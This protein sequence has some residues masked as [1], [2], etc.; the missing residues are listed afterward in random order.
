MEVVKGDLGRHYL[1]KCYPVLSF[2][3]LYSDHFSS[4]SIFLVHSKKISDWRTD[5]PNVQTTDPPNHQ[6]TYRLTH[7]PTDWLTD[8]PIDGQKDRPSYKVAMTQLKSQAWSLFQSFI[9][10]FIHSFI[11]FVIHSAIHLCAR[12]RNIPFLRTCTLCIDADRFIDWQQFP[13]GY[14]YRKNR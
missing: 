6:P 11:D 13:R 2:Y 1:L 12:A 5:R 14:S 4:F 3:L 7:H 8:W 9:H 10:S